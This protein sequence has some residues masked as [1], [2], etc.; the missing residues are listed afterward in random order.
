MYSYSYTSIIFSHIKTS[1]LILVLVS[2]LVKTYM[3][4]VVA[5]VLV[6]VRFLKQYF[7]FNEISE[8]AMFSFE[9]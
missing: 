1:G 5:F 7:S 4:Y 3:E 8:I 2:V 9:F 6:L